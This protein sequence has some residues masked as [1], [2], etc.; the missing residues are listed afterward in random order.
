MYRSATKQIVI[1]AS[2]EH[3]DSLYHSIQSLVEN[4]HDIDLT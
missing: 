3:F 4:E 1:E 2:N